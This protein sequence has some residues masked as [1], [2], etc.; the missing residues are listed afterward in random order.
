MYKTIVVVALLATLA[1]AAPHKRAASIL[2]TKQVLAEID[3]DKFGSTILSAV[4]LNMAVESPLEEITLLIDE[5]LQSVSGDQA[6][7]DEKNRTDQATCDETITGLVNQIREHRD[8]I[9][10][11][12]QSISDNEEILQ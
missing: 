12:T 8:A 3:Q 6:A 5:I 4:A 9:A 1:F 11:L 10:T 7:A 2:D